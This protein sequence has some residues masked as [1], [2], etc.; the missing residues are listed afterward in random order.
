MTLRVVS[1]LLAVTLL[2]A[3]HQQR[4]RAEQLQEMRLASLTGACLVDMY[5]DVWDTLLP[6]CPNDT[7]TVFPPVPRHPI[8]RHRRAK[9]TATG[10]DTTQYAANNAYYYADYETNDRSMVSTDKVHFGCYVIGLLLLIVLGVL[11][12]RK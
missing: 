5:L 8:I 12:Y 4:Q 1:V 10:K 9:L 6:V 7:I 2:M 3:C 11:G